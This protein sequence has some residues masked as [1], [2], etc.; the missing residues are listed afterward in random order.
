MEVSIRRVL[1][2]FEMLHLFHQSELR[3]SKEN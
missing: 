2:V 3:D 1:A